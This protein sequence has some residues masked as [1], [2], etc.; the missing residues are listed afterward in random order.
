LSNYTIYNKKSQIIKH[1]KQLFNRIIL[2]YF[3]QIKDM[4]IFK[5]K[6]ER[7]EKIKIYQFNGK[8]RDERESCFPTF[9]EKEKGTGTK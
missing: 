7:M 1:E 3:Q 5:S 8:T 2:L 4:S 9:T 6:E